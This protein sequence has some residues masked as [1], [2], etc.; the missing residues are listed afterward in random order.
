MSNPGSRGKKARVLGLG[1]A[2]WMSRLLVSAVDALCPHRRDTLPPFPHAGR[3]QPQA[4]NIAAA[5]GAA[6][7][8]G[9]MEAGGG[10]QQAAKRILGSCDNSGIFRIGTPPRARPPFTPAAALGS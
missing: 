9:V 5:G 10:G 1:L 6:R 7:R 8:A 4:S 2:P 3:R